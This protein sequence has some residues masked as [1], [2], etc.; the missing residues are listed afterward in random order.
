MPGAF[1]LYDLDNDGSITKDEML[2]IVTSIY[3]MVGNSVKLPD[4]ENT[5]EKRVERIFRMMDKVGA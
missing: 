5:P 4:E 2:Q 3:A 1:K